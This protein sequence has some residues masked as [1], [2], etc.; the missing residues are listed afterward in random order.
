MK[1]SFIG[2]THL[3]NM[4]LSLGLKYQLLKNQ[5]EQA[6]FQPIEVQVVEHVL[7]KK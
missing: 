3:Y 4:I 6:A 5:A 1:L 7:M 2:K